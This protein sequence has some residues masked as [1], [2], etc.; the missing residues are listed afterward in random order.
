MHNQEH[1]DKGD[2]S[3]IPKEGYAWCLPWSKEGQELASVKL[4]IPSKSAVLEPMQYDA[5]VLTKEAK[6]A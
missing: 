3:E 6:E 1:K 4:G 5:R 2:E